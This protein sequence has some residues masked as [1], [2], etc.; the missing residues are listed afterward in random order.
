MKIICEKRKEIEI[1]KSCKKE[2]CCKKLEEAFMT[3]PNKHGYGG[4]YYSQIRVNKDRVEVVLHANYDCSYGYERIDYC[5]FCGAPLVVENIEID[6]T[7][8]S[9]TLSDKTENLKKKHWW[10]K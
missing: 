7:G 10:N 4:D 9:P 5:P 8:L 2:F 1:V 3:I 6:N